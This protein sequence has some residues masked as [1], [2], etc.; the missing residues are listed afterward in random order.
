MDHHNIRHAIQSGVNIVCDD[1][2]VSDISIKSIFNRAFNV[3]VGYSLA[4]IDQTY[5]KSAIVVR[6][7]V[8]LVPHIVDPTP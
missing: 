6:I 7:P 4:E 1:S 3:N 5:I 8:I 2:N